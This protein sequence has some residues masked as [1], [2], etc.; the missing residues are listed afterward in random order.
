MLGDD[1]DAALQEL[2][3]REEG[4]GPADPTDDPER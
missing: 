4:S 2:L 3:S 1:F